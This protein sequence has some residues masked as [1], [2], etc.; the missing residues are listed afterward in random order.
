MI[1]LYK[2]LRQGFIFMKSNREI[3]NLNETD[4]GKHQVIYSKDNVHTDYITGEIT[5]GNQIIVKKPKTKRNL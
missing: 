1:E 3:Q 5:E 4:R 2:N